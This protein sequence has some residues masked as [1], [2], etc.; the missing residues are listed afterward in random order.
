MA[1]E[2]N[3]HLTTRHDSL[4]HDIALEDSYGLPIPQPTMVKGGVVAI[5]ELAGSTSKAPPLEPRRSI[6]FEDS[7]D[8]NRKNQGRSH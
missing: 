2:N 7:I 8:D 6:C 5:G 4:K 1:H 3:A